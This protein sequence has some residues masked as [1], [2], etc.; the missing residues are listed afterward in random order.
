M[1]EILKN[2]PVVVNFRVDMAFSFYSGGIYS[3]QTENAWIR[4]NEARPDWVK[5]DHAVLCYGWGEEN[6]VKYWLIQNSWGDKWGENGNFKMIR[7]DD[8]GGI[9]HMAE[10]VMPYVVSLKN[11]EDDMTVLRHMYGEASTAYVNGLFNNNN[12]S[13]KL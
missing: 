2:G 7:G 8:S 1:L 11:N 5:L 3:H 12:K 13:R 6:G 9:E 4:N 10:A